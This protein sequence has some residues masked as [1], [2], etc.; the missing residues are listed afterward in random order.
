MLMLLHIPTPRSR[1]RKAHRLCLIT[2][3]VSKTKTAIPVVDMQGYAV[4]ITVILSCL[5]W[6]ISEFGM[7]APLECSVCVGLMLRVSVWA[8]KCHLVSYKRWFQYVQ[9]AY[10]YKSLVTK[11]PPKLTQCQRPVDVYC[12]V[13]RAQAY[14]QTYPTCNVLICDQNDGQHKIQYC[15]VISGPRVL[16]HD[17]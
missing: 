15:K 8:D 5:G 14:S 3:T 1:I 13:N 6:L 4:H 17:A 7:T 2:Q 9:W 11:G 12:M 10:T 16:C